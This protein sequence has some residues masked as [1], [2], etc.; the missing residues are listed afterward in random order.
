MPTRHGERGFYRNLEPINDQGYFDQLFTDEAVRFLHEQNKPDRP[1]Y[2]N[3]CFYAPHSPYQTPPGYP[4]T[5]DRESNYRYMVEYLDKCVGRVLDALEQ[6]GQTRQTLIV[7]LSDQGGSHINQYGRT[8]REE[9]LKVIC[10]ARW[11][12]RIPA[13]V[14]VNSPWMHY[15]LYATFAALAG[16]KVPSDRVVDARNVWPLFEGNEHQ[17][18]RTLHWTTNENCFLDEYTQDAIR[19]ENWK[20]LIYRGTAT[21]SEDLPKPSETIPCPERIRGLYDLSADPD[22]EHDLSAEMPE[23]VRQMLEVHARWKTECAAQQ[24]LRLRDDS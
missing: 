2:M 5:G 19:M 11:P 9:S 15:D 13:S 22:E 21:G 20:L 4:S 6:I 23:R 17:L 10:N 16:A 1:F 3:L 18:D 8:L 14:R 24:T 7:F 12:G